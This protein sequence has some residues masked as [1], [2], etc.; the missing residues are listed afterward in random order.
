MRRFFAAL[1]WLLL[2]TVLG[3]AAMEVGGSLAAPHHPVPAK[4]LAI[5]GVMGGEFGINLWLLGICFTR[6]PGAR[7]PQGARRRFGL[8]QGLWGMFGFTLVMGAGGAL[9]ANVLLVENLF[10]LLHNPELRLDFTDPAMLGGAVL[11]GELMTGLWLAWS[12]RR[13]GPLLVEDGSARGIAWRDAPAMAYAQAVLLAMLLALVVAALFRLV[14]PD[15][16]ALQNLPLAKLFDGPPAMVLAMLGVVLLLG[17]ALEEIAF[18][19]IGFAGVASRLGQGGAVVLTTLLFLVAHAP[20]KLHYL[21]GFIDVGLLALA[22]CYLRLRY[23]SIRPGILLHVLYNGF[24]LV[25][26]AM[27]R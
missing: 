10:L 6:L 11:S 14:P 2:F 25:A 26:A 17:P 27:L 7:A 23:R 8:A 16:Q 12:L 24:G 4:A 22:A 19:G 15:L 18:R 9:F 5:L 13:L 1:G 3:A 21:P 20:E